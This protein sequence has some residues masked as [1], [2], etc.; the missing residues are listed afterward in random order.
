M[1]HLYLTRKAA[2]TIT[3]AMR[4][5][6]RLSQKKKEG[7]TGVNKDSLDD[8]MGLRELEKTMDTRL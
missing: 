5:Y 4:Y 6:L 8:K 7:G 3:S 2:Q 1:H